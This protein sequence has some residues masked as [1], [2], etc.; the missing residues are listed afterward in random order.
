M[1]ATPSPGAAMADERDLSVIIVNWNTQDLLR[2]CLASLDEH[3]GG[4]DHEVIVVDNASSDG[5]A[6]MVASEF[7]STRLIRN[8]ENVGFG[9][10]N[11]QAMRAARGSWFL[12]LNSDTMLLDRSVSALVERVREQP[13]L[14][15]AHCRLVFPDGR[16]QHTVYRFPS[17]RLALLEDLG[18]YK[19]MPKRAAG[20][21]LLSGYWTYDEERDVDWVAGAFML[22]PREVFDATGGFDERLFMYGEDLD[23]CYRIRDLGWRIRFYPDATVMHRDHSSAEIKWGDERITLCLV[24]QRDVYRRRHSVGR[25]AALMSLRAFGAALRTVY[26]T[27][28]TR[29]GGPRAEAYEDMRAYTARA[30]RALLPLMLPRR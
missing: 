1:L 13:G 2:D 21:E 11:N 24:T 23:W 9:R 26:Y 4:L 25:A 16:T 15:L 14:G 20:P 17:I 30:L 10:A 3:L 5:S 29:L 28:R 19:L 18:L 27:F 22:L 6:D 8:D 7:P 12:L